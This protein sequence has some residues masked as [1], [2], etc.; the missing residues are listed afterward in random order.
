MSSSDTSESS[1]EDRSTLEKIQSAETL[2]ELMPTLRD[3]D[4]S[5][6]TEDPRTF[7]ELCGEFFFRVKAL[8]DPTSDTLAVQ[9]EIISRLVSLSL[10]DVSK[11]EPESPNRRRDS[12][13]IQYE[14]RRTLKTLTRKIEVSDRWDIFHGLE[15]ELSGRLLHEPND[16]V[17]AT[18]STVGMRSS[19]IANALWQVARSESGMADSAICT[20]IDLGV[21][22]DEETSGRDLR[23]ELIGLG[24][25]KL[26]DDRLQAVKHIVWYLC[27]PDG[28]DLVLDAMAKSEGTEDRDF[29][30]DMIF[31]GAAHAID[32][33]D[34]SSPFHQQVWEVFRR[35]K[36]TINM[37][38][39]FAFGCQT[40]EPI[41]DY[42][43]WLVEDS[44]R[45]NQDIQFSVTDSRISELFKPQHLDGYDLVDTSRIVPVLKQIAAKDSGITGRF[46][47]PSLDAK[48][49]SVQWLQCMAVEELDD[50]NT[51][52]VLE[53]TN[54]YVA[55]RVAEL[56]STSIQSRFSKALCDQIESAAKLDGDDNENFFRQSAVIQLA[57]ASET[58]DAFCAMT[59]FGYL[60][61]GNVLL[62]VIDAL[63][64]LAI[65]RIAAG[66]P[67]VPELI[68][69][70]ISENSAQH[71]RE[72]G[73][74]TL[75]NLV[76]NGDVDSNIANRLWEFAGDQTLDSF[77]RA[78]CFVVLASPA[79][80]ADDEQLR[81]LREK[82]F[83]R[84]FEQQPE[85]FEGLLLRKGIP[86]S[87]YPEAAEFLGC[88]YIEDQFQ[89]REPSKVSA[90][91]AYMLAHLYRMEPKRTVRA[92]ES[93]LEFA[94]SESVH[95]VTWAIEE[96]ESNQPATVMERLHDRVLMSNTRGR[97]ETDLIRTL[98]IISPDSIVK[99]VLSGAWCHWLEPGRLALVENARLSRGVEPVNSKAARDVYAAFIRDPSFQVRRVAYRQ[100]ARLHAEAFALHLQVLST[101]TEPDLL[102]RAAEGIRWLPSGRFDDDF[103]RGSGLET[104]PLPE[105]REIARNAILERRNR[106]WCDG[107]T[108][109]I[110]MSVRDNRLAAREFRVGLAIETIGDDET[111]KRLRKLMSEPGVKP[112]IRFWLKGLIKAVDKQWKK[113]LG[114][115]AK[116]WSFLRGSVQMMEGKVYLA[117]LDKEISVTVHL[118]KHERK[119]LSE[120]Y[121]WGGILEPL[122]STASDFFDLGEA[123]LRLPDRGTCRIHVSGSTWSS[124]HNARLSFFSNSPWPEER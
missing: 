15:D 69:G 105:I 94:S 24:R 78:S 44:S 49:S 74:A 30:V 32:R 121:S 20:I 13:F 59:K 101:S 57:H 67:D 55:H 84:N 87:D 109:E 76:S 63:T 4:N 65:A 43:D 47:T 112:R 99:I 16:A 38:A 107:Y 122:D 19:E 52:I 54:P 79:V 1:A 62:S 110:E 21:P 11:L 102:S 28:M 56:L 18:V 98:G 41:R 117:E 25:T 42:L 53:E 113:T 45:G 8:F 23:S 50:L 114:Q 61:R 14:L 9:R 120:K 96:R 31:S 33:C 81:W 12:Q 86:I 51:S 36:A 93:I 83:S 22:K 39:S 6:A 118:W 27:G 58:R 73:V 7:W 75:C 85:A 89:I 64:E 37:N 106:E 40:P 3:I 34:A 119:S 115:S 97:A 92:I 77:S 46:V 35:N 48:K 70:M 29:S 82:A 10:E 80:T 5:R 123:E 90:W 111:L 108:N 116:P 17:F 72:A 68:L 95:Q 60:H 104:H 71:H 66:D 100:F 2:A 103:I 26:N 124:N 91:Q 88:S